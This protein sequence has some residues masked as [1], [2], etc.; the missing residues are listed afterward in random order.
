M[1]DCNADCTN[2]CGVGCQAML[3]TVTCS[4]QCQQACLPSCQVQANI[5]CHVN[6][7]ANV[8]PGECNLDCMGPKGAVFCGNPPQYIDLGKTA[9]ACV[10]YLQSQGIQASESCSTSTGSG[11]N[12][13]TSCSATV[14]CAASPDLG[15]NDRWG[16]LGITG[17]MMGVGLV[18]S[19]RRRRS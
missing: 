6:C 17:L 11:G 12:A 19:R 2:R 13:G 8:A 18:V 9:S 4:T 5:G 10:T 3:P 14:T 7:T 1:D 15:A 16:V